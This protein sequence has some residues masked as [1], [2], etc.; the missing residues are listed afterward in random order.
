MQQL[1]LDGKE[2]E[3]NPKKISQTYQINDLAEIKDR[4]LHYT[5]RFNIPPTPGNMKVMQYLGV[6]GSKS[7]KPY[8]KIPAKYI[9]NGIELMSSGWAKVVESDETG[10]DI[11]I[12][13]GNASL[14]EVLKGRR[15]N[16][17]DYNDLNHALNGTTHLESLDHTS[18]YIYALMDSGFA[19]VSGLVNSERQVA[20]LFKHTLWEKIFTEAGF[21]YSGDIFSDPIFL[22]E[23]VCP[24]KGYDVVGEE[25]SETAK[26]STSSNT[27]AKNEY[28]LQDPEYEEEQFD[29]TGSGLTGLSVQS[30]NILQFDVAGLYRV[31][32]TLNYTLTTGEAFLQL[33]L[34]G[35][36]GGGII[37]DIGGATF[38]EAEFYI[39]AEAGDQIE[40]WIQS[41]AIPGAPAKFEI[42]FTSDVDATYTLVTGGLIIKFEDIMP[43]SSQIDF[44]KDVM[45]TYGLIFQA[46]KNTNHYNFITME[47]LVND[48]SNA[49]DWTRKLISRGIERYVIGSYAQNNH[50]LYK[51]NSDEVQDISFDGNITAD[52]EN[53]KDDKTMFTS[54]YTISE[55]TQTRN[56]I[57]IYQVPLWIEKVEQE[58]TVVNNLETQF[59]SFN[60]KYI[61][62]AVTFK[63][64]DVIG[65]YSR[66]SNMPF[67]SLENIG[68]PF[69][70]VNYYPGFKRILDDQKKRI[71]SM[72]LKPN[73]IYHLDFL[74]LKYF[75]TLGQ[76]FYLNKVSNFTDA[77]QT[78]V[79]LIQVNELTVNQPPNQ[80]GSTL[81][82]MN[83]G[84]S[85]RLYLSHFTDTDPIYNDPE[86]DQPETIK[87]TAGWNSNLLIK[88]NGVAITDDTPFEVANMNLTIED[89]ENTS[90]EYT[91]DF[92]FTIQ[93]FNNPNFSSQSG[94]ISITINEEVNL[95]PTADAGF[96][97][98]M[99][100]DSVTN[101]EGTASL[102]GMGSSDPNDDVL[103]YL[104]TTSALPSGV[105]LSNENTATALLTGTGLI[106]SQHLTTITC[107]LRVTDPFG[108]WD[109]DTMI[110]QLVDLASV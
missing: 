99:P 11:N 29:L 18:G 15:M 107:T 16:D 79:E 31:K 84:G 60:L 101:P 110:V 67:L 100:Y 42:E 70:I 91:A 13:D 63:F 53:L 65:N 40:Y 103:I 45:R 25:T 108:L 89:Q 88:N 44:I 80:L 54:L 96:N 2:V 104:W 14:Y 56:T 58:G 72:L 7:R 77:K 46:T 33:K 90:L 78:K 37:M 68:Y 98:S 83:H 106:A 49:E 64:G 10:F 34:N 93:S 92:D 43:D 57:P 47:E 39:Q 19:T 59:R 48:R 69:Y 8:I 22:K 97:T 87:F 62:E 30:G 81:I 76:Y 71:V 27:I 3:L 6:I 24:T 28:L 102:I 66:A 55:K 52:H 82:T 20:A 21:T 23:V 86:F 41:H 94:R 75:K 95:A 38:E 1:F 105:T 73:D 32:V 17:L 9:Y 12:Y 85:G 4:Q 74:R 50:L 61:D 26:G 35:T 36:S 51:Y 109:E 5:N